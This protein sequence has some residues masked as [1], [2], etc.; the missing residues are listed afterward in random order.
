MGDSQEGHDMGRKERHMEEPEAGK[1][2]CGNMEDSGGRKHKTLG[3]RAGNY[4][5]RKS[6]ERR[7]AA[8]DK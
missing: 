7:I 6:G 2:I 1:N 5:G 3:G 4:S 8:G